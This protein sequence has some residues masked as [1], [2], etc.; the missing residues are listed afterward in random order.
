MRNTLAHYNNKMS[1]LTIEREQ[2]KT[3]LKSGDINSWRTVSAIIHCL[4]AELYDKLKA[5]KDAKLKQI[6]PCIP[7]KTT[8]KR[9]VRI[10]VQ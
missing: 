9:V 1:K 5:S 10:P 3:F 4:N 8:T 2:H 6:L 7:T